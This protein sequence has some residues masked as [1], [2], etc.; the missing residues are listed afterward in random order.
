MAGYQKQRRF[1][2]RITPFLAAS[3]DKIPDKGLPDVCRI[4]KNELLGGYCFGN[5]HNT[6]RPLICKK[7]NNLNQAYHFTKGQKKLS[8]KAGSRQGRC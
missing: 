7:K 6:H 5:D 2:L 4:K 1:C 3:G 8:G